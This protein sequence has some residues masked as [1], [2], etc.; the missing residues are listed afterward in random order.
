[1]FDITLIHRR[2]GYAI[3]TQAMIRWAPQHHILEYENA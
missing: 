1:M 3:S 2:L